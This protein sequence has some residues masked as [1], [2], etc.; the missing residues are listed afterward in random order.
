MRG[1]SKLDQDSELK[2]NAGVLGYQR[3]VCPDLLHKGHTRYRQIARNASGLIALYL[4]VFVI[5]ACPR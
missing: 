3:G 2:S 5:E 1:I 4:T